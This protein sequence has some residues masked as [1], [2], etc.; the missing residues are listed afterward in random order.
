MMRWI[1]RHISREVPSGCNPKS[2]EADV[3]LIVEGCY[4]Y[5][6]GGVSVWIDALIRSQ[7]PTTFAVVSLQSAGRLPARALEL[8]GNVGS[9]SLLQLGQSRS[10]R[11]SGERQLDI[12]PVRLADMLRAI[13][14]RG[15]R[16]AFEAL[17][18]QI[19]NIGAGEVGQ[20]LA[21]PAAWRTIVHGYCSEAPQASFLQ[22]YWAWQ[23]LFGGLFDVLA[24]PLPKARVYHAVSTG[25]AGLLGAR[26]AIE[27]GRPLVLTEHGI[28]T[29]ERLIEILTASWIAETTDA[30]EIE[31]DARVSLRAMWGRTF[32]GFARIAY[33]QASLIISL[34]PSNQRMQAELG[35]DSARMRVIPNGIDASLFA[36]LPRAAPDADP[37]IGLIA[38]VVPIKDVKTF[39]RAVAAVRRRVPRLRAYVLGTCE[40]D[41]DYAAECR[42]LAQL[43]DLEDCMSF[44]GDVDIRLYL[45]C[46]H[47]VALSSLSEGQPYALLEAGAAGVPC[48]ATDVG[49]C[50]ELILGGTSSGTAGEVGGVIVE[51]T[52]AEAMAAGLIKL[53]EDRRLGER[54]G[55]TLRS[56]VCASFTLQAVESSYREVYG[57]YCREADDGGHRI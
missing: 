23:A 9:F 51:P 48:V 7:S 25:F 26:A 18:K 38:R 47:V 3:C 30:S 44:E 4:P 21:G 36:G 46:L 31:P 22:Y 24:T 28:Y 53:L 55:D 17:L 16:E 50:R 11:L 56:R 19:T 52:D 41:P 8:P 33:D 54:Y 12:D 29:N 42:S 13:A 2:F 6:G 20:L 37:A 39:I 34:F 14:D 35:A 43:L 1:S 27:T 45:P 49:N 5:F 10:V 57:R 32:E 40:E 15:S